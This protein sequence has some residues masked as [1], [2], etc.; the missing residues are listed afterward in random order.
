M[1]VEELRRNVKGEYPVAG[2][3]A[4]TVNAYL[5]HH[6]NQW[7]NQLGEKELLKLKIKINTISNVE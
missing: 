7:K 3:H 1:D 5:M 2:V 4:I 6:L